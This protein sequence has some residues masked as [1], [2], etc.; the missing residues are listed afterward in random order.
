MG[1]VPLKRWG[2]A[3][4]FE[5]GVGTYTTRGLIN[6]IL[7]GYLILVGL[8]F[9]QGPNNFNKLLDSTLEDLVDS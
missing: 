4:F 9:S 7:I 2:A 6:D 3:K 5:F 1:Q 8:K